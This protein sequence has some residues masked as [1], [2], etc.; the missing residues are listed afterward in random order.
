[1]HKYSSKFSIFL[2]SL[3]SFPK[4]RPYLTACIGIACALHV[5]MMISSPTNR[6]PTRPQHQKLLVKTMM[7][8]ETVHTTSRPTKE[9]LNAPA[10]P[11]PPPRTTKPPK[12]KPA[13]TTPPPSPSKNTKTKQLLNDLQE[14]I[15]KIEAKRDNILPSQAMIIPKP[16]DALKAD[17]YDIHAETIETEET[18][19]KDGLILYLKDALHLPGYGTVKMRLTLQKD[20]TLQDVMAL[21]SDSEVNRLYLENTLQ[22]LI[23]PPFT[24]ELASKKTYTFV[25][26]FCSD[27]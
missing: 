22:E 27:Q 12:P 17:V 18:S 26:T 1:M 9:P 14:N 5:L 24:E 10:K 8:P 7:I 15:A 11:T 3:K 19:Y 4:S 2:H 23:F 13:L 6:L 20:G 21:S 25:L 16:I